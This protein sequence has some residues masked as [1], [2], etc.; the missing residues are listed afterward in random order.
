[1]SKAAVTEPIEVLKEIDAAKYIGMSRSFLRQ[2]R[3]NGYRKGRTPGP[4]YIKLGRTIR[5]HK[6][7]LDV[8][9]EEHRIRRKAPQDFI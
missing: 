7:D 5:Y 6:N 4:V 3:M 8:W 1:M 2:D 9:L